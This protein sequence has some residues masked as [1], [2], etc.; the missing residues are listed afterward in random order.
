MTELL[1]INDLKAWLGYERSADVVKWL[2]RNEIKWY[3]AKGGEPCT[4][5]TAING[6]FL[7]NSNQA[8]GF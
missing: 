6:R 8:V 7:E 5:L 3:P 4:T 2:E 1:N